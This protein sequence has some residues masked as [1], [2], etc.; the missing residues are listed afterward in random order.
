MA[1]PKKEK[2]LVACEAFKAKMDAGALNHRK[3]FFADEKIFRIGHEAYG[4]SQ[5]YR[6][7]VDKATRKRDARQGDIARGKQGGVSVMRALGVRHAGGG[8]LVFIKKEVKINANVYLGLPGHAAA[9]RRRPGLHAG[10]RLAPRGEGGDRE[11]GE[12]L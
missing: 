8:T 4:R 11:P 12:Q 3:I 1:E 5:N 2:R 7:W 10:R 9:H 6:A